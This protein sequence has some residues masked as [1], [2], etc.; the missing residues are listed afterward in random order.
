MRQ[1][2]CCAVEATAIALSHNNSE[3]SQRTQQ[4]ATHLRE[5]AASVAQITQLGKSNSDNAANADQL[6]NEARQLAESGGEVVTQAVSAMSTIN[7]GSAKIANIIGLIDEIAFQT[8]LLALNAAVEAAR[9]GEQG[10]G[11]AVVASEVRALAKRSADA[12][13]QIKAL[14]TDS[15]NS[16]RVGTELVDRTGSAL[17][18]IQSS[19]RDMTRLIKEIAS[20]SHEQAIGAQRINQ[21]M[22]QLDGATEQYAGWVEQGT[23]AA[24]TLRDQAD[25]LAQ[26]A[27]YF[28]L[29]TPQAARHRPADANTTVAHEPDAPSPAVF[30]RAG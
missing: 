15:A 27:A 19:V 8:N 23:S 7:K 29:Q 21:A 20:S 26:R 3:L 10:R 24:G 6:S 14:I 1:S 12:A 4:Q 22:V 16:V 9:A 13:K 5:T 18:Q 17:L 2:S 30:R 28:T 11:F 25:V